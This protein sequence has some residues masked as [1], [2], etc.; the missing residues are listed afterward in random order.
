MGKNLIVLDL[1]EREYMDLVWIEEILSRVA[2]GK[3]PPGVL[4]GVKD[5]KKAKSLK[6]RVTGRNEEMER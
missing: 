2:E 5:L 3:V 1:T 6:R 4:Y